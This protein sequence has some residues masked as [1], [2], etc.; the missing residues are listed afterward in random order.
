MQP[1]GPL[2]MH[3]LPQNDNVMS[4]HLNNHSSAE[5]NTNLYFT[6]PP[7]AISKMFGMLQAAQYMAGGALFVALLTALGSYLYLSNEHR[8]LARELNSR[9]Q[10]RDAQLS[11]LQHEIDDLNK[12]YQKSDMLANNWIEYDR[13][14]QKLMVEHGFKIPPDPCETKG[15]C[16]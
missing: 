15:Q 6:T 10:I 13:D 14:L 7:E 11:T 12:A 5:T 16:Q 3:I 9:K 2:R 8:D 1:F 4:D